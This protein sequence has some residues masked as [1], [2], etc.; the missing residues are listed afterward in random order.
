MLEVENHGPKHPVQ[1]SSLKLP[2]KAR[3]GMDASATK[4]WHMLKAR[5][6]GWSPGI[7]VL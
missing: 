5:D 2:L 1:S 3:L 4:R 7:S 6:Q